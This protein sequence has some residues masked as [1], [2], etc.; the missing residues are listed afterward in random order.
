MLSYLDCVTFPDRCDVIEVAD[1]QRYVYPMFKN[2]SSGLYDRARRQG[3]RIC[4]NQQIKNLDEIEV[5]LRPP[6]QRFISGVNSFIH[7]SQRDYPDLDTNTLLWFLEKYLH[8]DR[9]C[10]PQFLW[11]VNLARFMDAETKIKVG[12]M[13]DLDQLV[14]KIVVPEGVTA[15]DQSLIDR[16]QNLPN[17]EM[18]LRLDRA[19]ISSCHDRSLTFRDIANRT[20]ETDPAAYDWVVTRAKNIISV[21]P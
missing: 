20:K 12:D 9:H 6:E 17:N 7:F 15:P 18:Y 11:L 13:T 21:L 14:G 1:T 2:G 3:W 10:C 4:I 8:L 5:F 16:V 19:L